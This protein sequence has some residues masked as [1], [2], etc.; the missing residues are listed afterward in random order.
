MLVNRA[1]CLG[2]RVQGGPES[3]V[4]FSLSVS[5]SR[6][7]PLLVGEILSLRVYV[8]TKGIFADRQ[9]MRPEAARA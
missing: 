8:R 6:V 3:L 1:D 2:E 9:E 7:L 5:R 4:K